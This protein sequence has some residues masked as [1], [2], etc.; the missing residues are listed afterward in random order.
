VHGYQSGGGDRSALYNAVVVQDGK[1]LHGSEF[2]DG[3]GSG[4]GLAASL[5]ADWS[6]L[7]P[8]SWSY[9]QVRRRVLGVRG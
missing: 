3:D 9:W 8:R 7:H 6:S 2:G 1:I 4:G 5:L